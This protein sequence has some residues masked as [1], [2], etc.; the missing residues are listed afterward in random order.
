MKL[1]KIKY[2]SVFCASLVFI[3]AINSLA[4]A[5]SD[6]CSSSNVYFSD[7]TYYIALAYI[8]LCFAVAKYKSGILTFCRNLKNLRFGYSKKV[9]VETC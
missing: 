4:F 9:L 8:V 2:L 1:G 6:A 3:L 5:Q 7:A